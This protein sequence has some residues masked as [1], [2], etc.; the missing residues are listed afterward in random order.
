LRRP[1]PRQS[2]RSDKRKPTR[3]NAGSNAI[4]CTTM[5]PVVPKARSNVC[6]VDSCPGSG[7]PIV[8]A[9]K[10]APATMTTRLLRTGAHIGAAKLPR[11]LRIA[12][13]T[14]PRP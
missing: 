7:R 11:V 8:M 1:A 12:P 6:V 14:A 5:P 10:I 3:R 13:K 4:V 9:K 2:H